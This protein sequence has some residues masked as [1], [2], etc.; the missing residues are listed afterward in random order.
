MTNVKKLPIIHPQKSI[1]SR[2]SCW[3]IA[4]ILLVAFPHITRKMF[5]VFCSVSSVQSSSSIFYSSWSMV[6][7]QFSSVNLYWCNT[8]KSSTIIRNRE[9][10]AKNREYQETIIFLLQAILS[11][12]GSLQPS[13]DLLKQS[14]KFPGLAQEP[15][16]G[17]RVSQKCIKHF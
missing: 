16:V 9:Y 12:L 14:T 15:Y 7:F 2:H 5:L 3:L 8:I 10:Q 6:L 1:L 17:P 13:Q 4:A 11:I